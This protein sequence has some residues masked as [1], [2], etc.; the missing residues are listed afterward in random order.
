MISICNFCPLGQ[1]N[2]LRRTVTRII[3]ANKNASPDAIRVRAHPGADPLHND[4]REQA[5]AE[6]VAV[7]MEA[8]EM[9]VVGMADAAKGLR[10]TR[11]GIVDFEDGRR[12]EIWRR[13]RK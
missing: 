1:K 6:T 7:G 8:V 9:A 11:A 3:A 12:N 4:P 13:I 5:D 10:A 2:Q